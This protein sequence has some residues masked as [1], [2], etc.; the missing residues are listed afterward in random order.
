M[1]VAAL[2]LE[3]LAARVWGVDDGWRSELADLVTALVADPAGLAD[4]P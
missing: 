2:Y 3:P 1:T 4:V